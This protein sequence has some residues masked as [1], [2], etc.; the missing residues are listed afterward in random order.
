MLPKFDKTSHLFSGTLKGKIEE[1]EKQPFISVASQSVL[2]RQ[3][4][5][6]LNL[7]LENPQNSEK[8][9]GNLPVSLMRNDIPKLSNSQNT[10]AVIEKTDG[11]RYLLF[12][13]RYKSQP[14]AALLDRAFN[15]YLLV[16]LLCYEEVYQGTILDVEYLIDKKTGLHT[17]WIF[18]VIATFGKSLIG[19]SHRH[20][21][22]RIHTAKI[23]V[24]ECIFHEINTLVGIQFCVKEPIPIWKLKEFVQTILPIKKLH[25]P[26][27]G[28]IFVC[29]E[30]AY[31]SGQ[32]F[33]TFKWKKENDHT[34]EFLLKF[35]HSAPSQ[36]KTT[37]ESLSYSS[38]HIPVELWVDNTPHQKLM[39]YTKTFVEISLLSQYECKH[40]LDLDQKIVE[41]RLIS[42][43]W[44][45]EKIRKD[46]KTPNHFITIQKTE[47][48]IRENVQMEELF[49]QCKSCNQSKE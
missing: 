28:L 34:A 9:P 35:P 20:Y 47:E 2:Y 19:K 39:F 14:V 6:K 5:S 7:L 43:R 36:V 31:K 48:N 33:E 22:D 25:T 29:L 15:C 21:I 18:D 46:K 12:F 40:L 1:L 13:T 38:E 45:I 8:F 17:F 26:I 41:C 30:N 27:D 32:D 16:D 24:E 11:I 3:I 44:V 23:L 4:R 49:C 37:L 42:E 10:Y